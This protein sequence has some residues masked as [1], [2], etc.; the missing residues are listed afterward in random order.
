MASAAPV[1]EGIPELDSKRYPVLDQK[2]I[3]AIRRFGDMARMPLGDWTGLTAPSLTGLDFGAPQFQ[4][5]YGCYALALAHYH[6]LPAAPG[7][8]KP[9]FERMIARVLNWDVWW[10]WRDV[11]KGGGE[12]WKTPECDGWVDPIVKDNI[13]YS[14]YVQTMALLYNALFDDDR[15]AQKGALTVKHNPMFW[16]PQGGYTFEYDQNSINEVIY[17]GMVEKGYLG[18]ACEPYC[19]F[20]ICNQPPILGFRLHD[21]LT[22]GSR[23]EEVTA[24]YLKAWQDV[25]GVID[26]QGSYQTVV[27]THTGQVV[28]GMD[29]WSDAWMGAL[30]HAWHPEFVKEHYPAQRDKYLVRGKDGTISIQFHHKELLIPYAFGWMAIWASEVGDTETAEGLLAHADKY[31]KPI[32]DDG[33]YYYRRIDEMYDEEGNLTANHPYQ[34]SVL[35]AYARLNVPDG[36]HLLYKNPWG[37]KHFEEPALT[38]VAFSLEVYRAI[39]DEN[40]RTLFFDVA[41]SETKKPGD[42][43][44]S[45]VFKRGK[46]TL[47]RDGKEIAHGTGETL[48]SAKASDGVSIQQVGEELRLTINHSDV[49]SYS[50]VWRD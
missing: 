27:A 6:R 21:H 40:I 30:M 28:P 41:R 2:Q 50:L 45:R 48:V 25:G 38:E 43:A 42:I 49:S 10:Y 31:M 33:A 22:G 47:T 17:W 37:K 14:A 5:A 18:V 15:Y 7:V 1:F 12:I 13:M 39:Y 9:L 11:S 26:P 44:L 24:G 34:G 35:L 19:V 36:L 23:A 32:W 46:W 16:G 20:Q 29:A 3:G 4:L 8:F